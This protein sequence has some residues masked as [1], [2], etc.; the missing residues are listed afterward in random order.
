MTTIISLIL[1]IVILIHS[2]VERKNN[3]EVYKDTLYQKTQ[4]LKIFLY[5]LSVI[6]FF[7]CLIINIV[8]N[9]NPTTKETITIIIN[10]ISLVILFLPL[11][12]NNLYIKYFKD[13]EKYSHIKTIITNKYDKNLYK[14]FKIADI[15]I[16]YLSEDTPDSKLKTIE[17]FEFKKSFLK[18]NLHIKTSNSKLLD[19]Y[20]KENTI[21]KE[22]KNL[23]TLYN[24]IEN[25]RGVHDNYIR[26]ITY[27][28]RTYL[29][30]II[31]YISLQ[32]AGFPIEYNLL[33]I[34]C[35][36]VLTIINS[37][38]LYKTLP[39]DKDIMERKVK[40]KNI[41]LGTQELFLTII[42]SFIVAFA[43]LVP[44]MYAI[45]QG[46]TQALGNTLYLVT[47]ICTQLLITISKLSDSFILINFIKSLKNIKLITFIIVTIILIIILNTTTFLNTKNI[48][49]KNNI[50]C[51]L[52]SLIPVLFI[53][54]TKLARYSTMKGKKKNE[55]K[56]NKKQRRS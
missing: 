22:T 40:D 25:A 51:L 36:K 21:I 34:T 20:L 33:C 49:L 43:C 41:L 28:I 14:K 56:N 54:I 44:Y 53:E 27:L 4:K 48:E 32:I 50:S 3:K 16:I 6:S 37:H 42:E 17:E 47:F 52:F 31:S 8:S 11:S 45:S 30:L 55:L 39:Y 29:T 7:I 2:I 18:K 19:K 15:N 12:L 24:K 1:L 9:P 23:N 5:I 38:Y 35:I 46:G 13:E 26:S 10:C